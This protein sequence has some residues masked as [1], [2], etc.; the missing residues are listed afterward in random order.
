MFYFQSARRGQADRG[1][2]RHVAGAV[3]AGKHN[4]TVAINALTVFDVVYAH[5]LLAPALKRSVCLEGPIHHRS[6]PQTRQG[7]DFFA[8]DPLARQ[9]CPVDPQ[10]RIAIKKPNGTQVG[11]QAC[12]ILREKRR[13]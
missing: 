7:F 3:A 9:R 1:E 10:S 8:L 6:A 4:M 12:A 5:P 11:R 13:S 2:Y